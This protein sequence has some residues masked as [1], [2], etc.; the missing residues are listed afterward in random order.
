M[1]NR[2]GVEIKKGHWVFAHGPRGARIEGRVTAIDSRSDFAKAY[3]PQITLDSGQTVGADDISQTLGKMEVL[4]DGTVRQNPTRSRA[5]WLVTLK[6]FVTHK[7]KT[8]E[9][10]GGLHEAEAVR[11]AILKAGERWRLVSIAK[12]NPLT[13]VRIKSPP[14]RPAG[15]SGTPSPRLVKR[16]KKTAKAAPGVYANPL[17]YKSAELVTDGGTEFG[18][19]AVTPARFEFTTLSRARKSSPNGRIWQSYKLPPELVQSADFQAW[20]RGNGGSVFMSLREL[21]T[22]MKAFLKLS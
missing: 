15:N 13:R 9:M 5:V 14:Q 17:P 4:A 12:E 10:P 21:Q 11:G 20:A 8:V 19:D 3:G 1:R 2:W 7:T 22:K 16:R 6:N 18:V